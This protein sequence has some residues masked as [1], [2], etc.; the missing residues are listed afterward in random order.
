MEKVEI[1]FKTVPGGTYEEAFGMMKE[2][3]NAGLAGKSA[4]IIFNEVEV[5]A[6]YYD[7]CEESFRLYESI[8]GGDLEQIKQSLPKE[9]TEGDV[10][11]MESSI[12]KSYKH[13][14]NTELSPEY[15]DELMSEAKS[16]GAASR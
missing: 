13:L 14:H 7:T 9:V 12:A 1:Q 2:Y 11:A 10:F 4:K 3:Q 5:P 6:G 15:L 8:V 16:G